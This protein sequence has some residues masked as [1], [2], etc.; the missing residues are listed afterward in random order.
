MGR[1]RMTRYVTLY[2]GDDV[3]FVGTLDECAEH[4][5]VKRATIQFYLSPTYHRRVARREVRTTHCSP[6]RARFKRIQLNKEIGL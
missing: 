6:W 3:L 2:R 5:G 4:L 1:R